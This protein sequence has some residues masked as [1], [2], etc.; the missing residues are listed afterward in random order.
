[1]EPKSLHWTGLETGGYEDIPPKSE[2]LGI[3]DLLF[4]QEDLPDYEEEDWGPVRA[5]I[6]T[7]RA[8]KQARTEDISIRDGL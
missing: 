3:L 8:I 7:H 2:D 1:T 4:T 6:A 5:R